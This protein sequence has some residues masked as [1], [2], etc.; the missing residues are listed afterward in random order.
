MPKKLVLK[1]KKMVFET[2]PVNNYTFGRIF[3]HLYQKSIHWNQI[4]IHFCHFAVLDSVSPFYEEILFIIVWLSFF[5]RRWC[6]Y[7]HGD[8]FTCSR[9]CGIFLFFCLTSFLSDSLYF[10]PQKFDQQVNPGGP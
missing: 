4:L 10:F 7:F 3:D 5:G 8:G 2:I 9:T 6:F 1:L